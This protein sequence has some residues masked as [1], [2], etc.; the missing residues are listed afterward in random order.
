MKPG[1]C[2]RLKLKGLVRP[3]SGEEVLRLNRALASI[4]EDWSHVAIDIERM[5]GLLSE[6]LA[7]LV[8]AIQTAEANGG[9]VVLVCSDPKIKIVIDMLG[10]TSVFK[11][12]SDVDAAARRLGIEIVETREVTIVTYD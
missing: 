4:L 12:E 7:A 2:L 6:H 11:M 9:E 8:D 3:E 1:A 5:R 10:L